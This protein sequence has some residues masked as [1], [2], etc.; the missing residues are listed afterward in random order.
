MCVSS[1]GYFLC[2]CICKCIEVCVSMGAW[3]WEAGVFSSNAVSAMHT[4]SMWLRATHSS[5]WASEQ[6]Y[7]LGDLWTP[8]HGNTLRAFPP[9]T[10]IWVCNKHT[11]QHL[12]CHSLPSCGSYPQ[13]RKSMNPSYRFLSGSPTAQTKVSRAQ[14][15]QRSPF[16]SLASS[17]LNV[18]LL[19]LACGA[20]SMPLQFPLWH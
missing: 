20:S 5:C 2:T 7:R 17:S 1:W 13:P 16:H 8:P 11:A 4:Q 15:T 10:Y 18:L 6:R 3:W 9:G 19:S 12:A 14:Q